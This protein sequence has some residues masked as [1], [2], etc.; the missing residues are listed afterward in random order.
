[1]KRLAPTF[2]ILPLAAFAAG[3]PLAPAPDMGSIPRLP[4]T[5]GWLGNTLLRG[6]P[7]NDRAQGYLQLYTSDLDVSPEGFVF[8]TTPWE[9]GCR[10]AG[11]YRDGDALPAF[12]P[13]GLNSGEAVSVSDRRVAY[14]RKNEVLLFSREPGR[15]IHPES[16]RALK[17]AEPPANISG[18]ALDEDH[19]RVWVADGSSVW[20]ASLADGLPVGPR[21]AAERAAK[22][23]VDRRGHLW[24]LQRAEKAAKRLLDAKPAMAPDG[25]ACVLDFG[26][27][28]AV[29]ALKFTHGT[30]SDR[31]REAVFQ[32]S[33]KGPDGPWVTL[34]AFADVPAGWPDEWLTVDPAPPWRAIRLA[35]PGI[36]VTKFEAWTPTPAAT[37]R[38]SGFSPDGKPLPSSEIPGVTEPQALGYD[39]AND[40]LLVA[41]DQVRFFENLA[42]APR[43]AGGFR[44][45]SRNVRG[46]GADA[47]GNLYLCTVG[48]GGID[49]TRL[50]SLTPAGALRWRMEGFAFLNTADLDPA[51]PSSAWS[52][53]QRYR[54]DWSLAAGNE[55]RAVA[56]T[57]DRA[58]F[59][60]D[61]RLH[62]NVTLYGV[63]RIGEK[64]FL[65][66]TTQAG[67]P[68]CIYRFE[69]DTAVPCAVASL[70]HSG[71]PW[72]PWQPPGFGPFLWRDANGDGQF[73]PAE[74]EKGLR[75]KDDWAFMNLDDR[76]DLWVLDPNPRKRILRRIPAGN[77]D[78]HGVPG[79]SLHSPSNAAFDL[80]APFDTP[81]RETRLGGFEV[82]AERGVVFLFG[83][84]RDF[85][86]SKEVGMN[87]PLGRLVLR[88]RIEGDRLVPTHLRELPY[89]VTLV[90]RPRDQA[91]C[92]ALAG[93]FL[94]VGFMQH[95]TALALRADDLSPVGRLDAGP[96]T[97]SPIF[98]GPPEL[99][100]RKLPDGYVLFMPQYLGNATTVLRWNGSAHGWLPPPSVSLGGDDTRPALA[101]EPVPGATGWKLERRQLWPRGWGP[102]RELAGFPANAR[103]WRDDAPGP[104]ATAYRLRAV[105]ANGALSDWSATLYRRPEAPAR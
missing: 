5:T 88:A 65:V 96:S 27:P 64:P 46:L 10:S 30:K 23:R 6:T 59:P 52:A 44:P 89:D 14:G 36:N 22:V 62:R 54:M 77:L 74:Y 97:L 49:Q 51:D 48:D 25:S 53:N 21:M 38:V 45:E 41:D 1:M 50:D 72:P 26:K 79:W 9:E 16:K 104:S 103:S 85:P 31:F 4:A 12:A 78:A 3:M 28:V 34:A 90:S 24:V 91:Y 29:C 66:I 58:R 87:H 100:A 47:Q 101:W 67:K 86:H 68:L 92:S 37:G 95:M 43:A 69:G 17:V 32:G 71:A 40:R 83:F 56:S 42:G 19:E 55:W 33:A 2:A 75:G 82:D 70:H 57:L 18:L 73:Q 76:G 105:G 61:P 80:P 8:L 102:W 20:A 60:D 93:E 94:F 99:I 7:F 15:P 81:D 39:A 63:R 13:L 11:V 84:T 98:D 35:G